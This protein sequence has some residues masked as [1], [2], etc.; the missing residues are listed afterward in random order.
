MLSPSNALELASR[1]AR[2]R[3]IFAV[4]TELSSDIRGLEDEA[5]EISVIVD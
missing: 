1:R 2:A 4:D 5:R 3:S